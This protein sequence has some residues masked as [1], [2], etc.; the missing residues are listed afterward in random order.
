MGLKVPDIAEI[1]LV[2]EQ[3]FSGTPGNKYLDGL[4]CLW[5]S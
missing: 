5:L 1:G 3:F 2:I 4:R